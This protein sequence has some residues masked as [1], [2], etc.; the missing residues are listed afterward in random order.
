MVLQGVE[1]RPP[2]SVQ[3]HH[4]AV[5]HCFVRERRERLRDCG[6]SGVEILVVPRSKMH[7]AVGLDSQGSVAVQ[8]QLVG[9]VR[10]FGQCACGQQ[11]HWLGE[12]G[13][14]LL[15]RQPVSYCEECNKAFCPENKH[16]RKYCSPECGHKVAAR[17]WARNKRKQG[18]KQTSEKGR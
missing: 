13:F 18:R 10:A 16:E 17:K 1:R 6:I 15:R 2:G 7:L 12:G 8:L 3:R 4:L 14:D 11:Q 9:L 5:D